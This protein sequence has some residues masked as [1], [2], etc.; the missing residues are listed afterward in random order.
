MRVNLQIHVASFSNFSSEAGHVLRLFFMGG[1]KGELGAS[2]P[3]FYKN[4]FM[5][6]F[7]RNKPRSVGLH[8]VMN[9]I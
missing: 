6:L 4:F 7:Q 5:A 2:A 9:S 8:K 3:L 1:A